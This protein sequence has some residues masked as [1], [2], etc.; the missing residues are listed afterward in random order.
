MTDTANPVVSEE[1]AKRE[2]GPNK[3][4]VLEK[5]VKDLSKE[6]EMLYTLLMGL[7]NYTG[8]DPLMRSLGVDVKRMH[9]VGRK[10]MGRKQG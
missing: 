2:R 6:V 9:K 10:E 5:V 3:I 1:K 4:D 7:A 8:Q